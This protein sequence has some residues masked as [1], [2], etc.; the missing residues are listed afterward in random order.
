[1][2]ENNLVH[3]LFEN[4]DWLP[5][6]L[7]ALEAEGFEHRSI[8]VCEGIIAEPPAPG[9]YLNRMSPSS[10]TRGN[11]HSVDLT[12]EMLAWL[13]RHGARV[14]NGSR[15]FELEMSKLRQS[16]ALKKYGILTPRTGLAV[17]AEHLVAL[18][19]SF[20]GPFI[21]KHNRGGKGLGIVLFSSSEELC[22]HLAAGTF[23]F[24][25][26]GQVIIQQYIQAARPH[27]TRVEIVG[28][29]MILA[30]QSSTTDGFELCPS[31][32]C[33]IK[34][35]PATP[36]NCPIDGG[37]KFSPSP[38]SP[39]DPLVARY[40]AMCAGEGIEL[41][42]IEFVEDAQGNRYTYDI[43]GTTNYNQVLGREIGVDGMR[44]LARYL[45]NVVV[46]QL[47]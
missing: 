19:K 33:Q 37:A 7:S 45:R 34:Q 46:P 24:G 43:N 39:D 3:I 28:S 20:E 11:R 29:K 32:A 12:R 25:P 42:G 9:I 44:E 41:A 18:A 40:I 21:T 6:L 22:D 2:N 17:G 10:H 8:A 38:L 13:E 16:M 35:A 4:P 23:D 5:P 31:D 30:M 47:A 36:D 26:N 1:M 15:A 27:I 14:I